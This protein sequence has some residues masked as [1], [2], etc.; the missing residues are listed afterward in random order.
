MNY[1][2]KT[3]DEYILLTNY[4]YGWDEEVFEE[5]YPEI[6]Q[7]AKEYLLNTNA[8]IKIIKRRKAIK[9]KSL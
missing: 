7:R 3:I 2:R 1:Q 4:G 8:Q 9:E 6:K 5:T